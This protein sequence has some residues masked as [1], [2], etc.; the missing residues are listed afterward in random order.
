MGYEDFL[1]NAALGLETALLPANLLYC[2]IGVFVGMIIG[3]IPGVGPLAAMS[4]LFPITFYVSP[5]AA[6]IMLAGI[7]YGSSYGGSITSI[8]LN[9]PGTPTSAVTCLDGNPMARKGRAG[10]ALITTTIASFVGGSVGIALMMMFSPLIVALAQMFSSAEYFSLMVLGLL[11]AT[12]ISDGSQ[13]KALAMVAMGLLFGTVGLDL[14]TGIPRYT[15]GLIELSDGISLIALAM[16]IFGFSEMI[17]SLRGVKTGEVRRVTLKSLIPAR[18]D[19]RRWRMAMARGAA[20]GSFFGALPGVGP[21]VAAFLAYAL[22]K[23]VS[24][25]PERF[26]HGAVEGVASPEAA[27]N[28]ADQTA[29]IPTMTL[30][31][32][33]SA[34]MALVLGV[35]IMHGIT[36]GPR[37]LTEHPDLFWGLV[38]SFWVGNLMLLLL[39]VPL[40]GVWVRL[41]Q[42]PYKWL[43]PAVVMFICIGVYSVNNSAFDVILALLFGALGYGLRVL[44]F[45]PA[46]LLLGFVLGP[47]MEEHFVRAIV[48]GHGNVL[49]F[50][51]RPISAV[52]IG[53]SAVLIIWG[54][55]ST[56]RQFRR[57][58]RVLEQQQQ[59]QPSI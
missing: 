35:L 29:F 41:L 23:R 18:D 46:P 48:L 34:T 45:S 56:I 20:V 19:V 37:L 4:I 5:T 53:I 28:A 33:G 50:L 47:L 58:A 30:G 52:V 39:N 11:A 31:I 43:Y 36:P 55:Y 6:L 14:N 1:A 59:Q 9:V 8:L 25:N 17:S 57:N 12:I 21:G 32:P 22:E 42:I 26:G 16:G 38:M 15:F 10:V 51:E 7:Y 54:A 40:V 3:V 24:R 13:V 49:I 44:G 27:N 2:F